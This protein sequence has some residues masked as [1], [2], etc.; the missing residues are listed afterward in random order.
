MRGS[1]WGTGGPD[2]PPGESQYIGYLAI[3]AR[4]PLKSQSYRAS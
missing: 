4:I 3:L 1:R 2:P